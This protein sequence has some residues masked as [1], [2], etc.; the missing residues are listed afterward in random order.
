MSIKTTIWK[1]TWIVDGLKIDIHQFDA[2]DFIGLPFLESG[3][4]IK[5]WMGPSER[6]ENLEFTNPELG[7]RKLKDFSVNERRTLWL[8]I[9]HSTKSELGLK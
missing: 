9:T 8:I 2:V 4:E 3:T 1:S 7:T 5:K 6:L